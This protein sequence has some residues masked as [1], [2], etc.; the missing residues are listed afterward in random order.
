MSQENEPKRANG[1]GPQTRL[2]TGAYLEGLTT[3]L[4][5]AFETDP[6]WSWAFPNRKD[7]AVWSLL[8]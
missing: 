8:S 1:S 3:T 6:L 4:T 5:A 7:L 2:A